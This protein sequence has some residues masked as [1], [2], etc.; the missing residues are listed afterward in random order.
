MAK[1]IGINLK[2]GDGLIVRSIQN[3]A[4][5]DRKWLEKDNYLNIYKFK[6]EV[7]SIRSWATYMT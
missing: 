3:D 4:I 2:P 1:Q 5:N 7:F 6:W